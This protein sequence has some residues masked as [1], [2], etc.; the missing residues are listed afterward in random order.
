MS[1]LFAISCRVNSQPNYQGYRLNR[2]VQSFHD[3][4]YHHRSLSAW[5]RHHSRWWIAESV[6]LNRDQGRRDHLRHSPPVEFRDMIYASVRTVGTCLGGDGTLSVAVV[7]HPTFSIHI[8][9]LLIG[10]LPEKLLMVRHIRR[11]L[12]RRRLLVMAA[13]SKTVNVLVPVSRGFGG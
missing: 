6:L 12:S 3:P 4:V 9:S 11:E 7:D 1:L 5:L 8:F 10:Q 13:T 2:Q